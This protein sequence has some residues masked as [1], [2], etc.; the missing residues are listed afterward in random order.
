METPEEEYPYHITAISELAKNYSLENFR[1]EIGV[2]RDVVAKLIAVDNRS[3]QQKARY[4]ILRILDL[5]LS[6]A[7]RWVEEEADLM[8]L[9]IRNLIELKFWAKFVSESEAK[10]T[11]FLNEADIDMKELY[12]RLEKMMPAEA[13]KYTLP[14]TSGKRV[15]VEPTGDHEEL[16]WKTAC[17]LIH[18]SSYVINHFEETIKNT[19]NNQFSPPKSWSTAGE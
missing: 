6:R 1:Y 14:Q 5:Q 3:D 8:A 13:E 19:A 15:R 17:K 16:T 7:V 18:P 4:R 9:V 12:Q 11:Q 10:A 2:C